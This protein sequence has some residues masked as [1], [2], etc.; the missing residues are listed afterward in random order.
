LGKA[1]SPHNP[2]G[3]LAWSFLL[4]IGLRL[5]L[6]YTDA[7]GKSPP[8]RV[9]IDLRPTTKSPEALSHLIPK[10]VFFLRKKS[11]FL[12]YI[13]IFLYEIEIGKILTRVEML[14]WYSSDGG[15]KDKSGL[16][17]SS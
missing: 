6:I 11:L 8:S 9:E 5:G 1:L 7:V 13:Y 3:L 14:I 10:T 4:L 15:R 2:C 17:I 16:L 12:Y